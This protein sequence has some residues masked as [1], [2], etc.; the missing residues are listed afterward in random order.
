MSLTIGGVTPD[1]VFIG[2]RTRLNEKEAKLNLE[3]FMEY[4]KELS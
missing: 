3:F 4:I 1:G 2:Y